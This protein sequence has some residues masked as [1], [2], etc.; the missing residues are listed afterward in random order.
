MVR[1]VKERMMFHM[2]NLKTWTNLIFLHFYFN[3]LCPA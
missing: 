3:L 2:M 1:N